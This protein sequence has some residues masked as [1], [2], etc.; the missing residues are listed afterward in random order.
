LACST[1]TWSGSTPQSYTY[2][3][4]RNGVSISGATGS[5]YLLAESDAGQQF[6]CTVTATNLSAVVASATSPTV[7]IQSSFNGRFTVNAKTG[8]VRF[9][10]TVSDPG[11]LDWLLTFQNGKFGVFAA[12][13]AKCAK[14]KIK[15]KG[16]CRP[17]TVAYAQGSTTATAAGTIS[18]TANPTAAAKKALKHALAKHKS[19]SVTAMLSFQSAHGGSPITQTDTIAVKPKKPTKP[20]KAK[21]SGRHAT[22]ATVAGTTTRSL[23]H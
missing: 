3:W 2:Q 7:S 21:H 13:K 10:E 23:A 12:E 9:I 14:G 1:G 8:A 6:A 17:A 4:L 20:K 22:G 11:T 18:F 16:K 15:L 5:G 19:I